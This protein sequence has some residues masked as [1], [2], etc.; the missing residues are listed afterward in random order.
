[1]DTD[2]ILDDERVSVVLCKC[3]RL[4]GAELK[5]CLETELKYAP[6]NE[7]AQDSHIPGLVHLPSFP[8]RIR[9]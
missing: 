1:M 8:Y 3:T 5:L 2:D 9:H 4:R 7:S 6:S